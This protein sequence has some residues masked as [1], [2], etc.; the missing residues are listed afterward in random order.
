MMRVLSLKNKKNGEQNLCW[1]RVKNRSKKSRQ[2]SIFFDSS[3]VTLTCLSWNLLFGVWIRKLKTR[4]I[5][6]KIPPSVTR[7]HKHTFPPRTIS[8][9]IHIFHNFHL[10]FILFHFKL[11][12]SFCYRCVMCVTAALFIQLA[13]RTNE[14]DR[15]HFFLSF[16]L[17]WSVNW[18]TFIYLRQKIQAG[19][20]WW[21][22]A[23]V[24]HANK[25]I[26][27]RNR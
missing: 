19:I 17:L 16:L 7:A 1:Y 4:V 15:E 25:L 21:S 27:S 26:L 11:S 6:L 18:Q 23:R 13:I 10:I 9:S 22:E 14:R 24:G 12:H 20:E 2:K 5:F 8:R 3:G